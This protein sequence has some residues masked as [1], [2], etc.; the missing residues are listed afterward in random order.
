MYVN[1]A[2]DGRLSLKAN[3]SIDFVAANLRNEAANGQT[4]IISDGRI[5]LGTAK[6]SSHSKQGELSDRNHRHVAQTS[7]AGTVIGAAGDILIS[8]KDDLTIRQGSIASDGGRTTLS[9]RNV[10]I[11]E[12]RQTLDLDDSLYN[13]SRSMVSKT[14]SLDQ[15]RRQHDEAV[16]SSIEGKEVVVRAGQDVN[17]RGSHAVSDGLTV[18]TAGNDVNIT[19]A[20]N[21]YSDHEF[22]ERKRSGLTASLANGVAAVGYSKSRHSLQQDGTSESL[23]LSQI[24][25][26]T[27]TTTLLAGEALNISAGRLNAGGDLNL[28]GRA[29]NLDAAYITDS[30]RSEQQ[31]KQS[32]LSIGVTYN[33]IAAAKTAYDQ[34]TA[35]S[36]NSGSAVGTWFARDLAAFKAGQA[37]ITP[38]VVGGGRSK[39]SA[40]QNNSR[41]QA[42]VSELAAGQHLN[43]IATEGGIRSEGAQISAEG[44]ALLS[45]RDSIRLGFAADDQNQSA[46]SRRSGLSIDNRDHLMPLG[47]FN[48]RGQGEGAL[49]HLTG[50]S[51]SVGGAAALQSGRDIDVIGSTIVAQNNLNLNAAGN[52][53]ILSGQ[54]RQSLSETQV[55]S[56]IG[57][58][59]ISDTEYFSGWMKNRQD[60]HSSQVEQ[61]KSQVGSLGGNVNMQAGAGY[62]QQVADVAAAKDINITANNINILDD[63]NRGSSHQSERDVKIGTFAKVSSPLIELAYAVEDAADSN[64]G[65]RTR[66]LQGMAAAAQGYQ[67][68][69]AVGKVTDAAA[70]NTKVAADA[71]KNGVAVNPDDLQQGAVLAKAEAGVGFKTAN[72]SQN[73]SYADSRR[74]TLSAGGNLTLQS[75]GGDIRLQHTAAT[76]GGTLSLDSAQ[77][78]SLESG[79]SSRHRDGKNSSFGASVGVGVSVG[80]QTG[81]YVYAEAGAT[82]GRQRLD[83]DGHN[84]TELAADK[85]LLAG[86]GDTTL[87]GATVTANRIDADVKGRLNIESVQDT[88]SQ[89]SKQSGAGARIQIALGS[90]WEASGNFNQSKAS[91]SS[92]TVHTQSGLFAGDGGYHI[93]ADS[94]HLKGGAIASTAAKENNGLTANALTFEDI[95]NHSSYNASGV[96]L[97]GGYGGSLSSSEAFQ[98]SPLGQ[99]SAVAGQ[100]ISQGPGYSPTLP[101]YDSGSDSSITR[102]TLSAGRLNIGGQETTT[103]ALGIHSDTETAHQKLAELPDIQ[104]ILRNQQAAASATADITSA[105]RTF[106]GNMAQKAQQKQAELRTQAEQ[107]L[108]TYDSDA[109]VL[110]QAMNEADK[111]AALLLANPEYAQSTQL[112]Q[113]WGNGGSKARA[114]NAVTA[115]LTGVLRGQTEVQATANALAPY[116]AAG[117]GNTFGHGENKNEAAQYAL[118]GILGATLAYLNNANPLSGGS[119]AIASEAAVQSLAAQYN[120]GQTAI[121][122]TTGEFNPNLLSESEKEKLRSLSAAIGSIFGGIAGNSTFNTQLAGVIGQNAVE[123]NGLGFTDIKQMIAELNQAETEQQKQAV[124]N[125]YRQ[126]GERNRQ[127]ELAK[128]NNQGDECHLKTLDGL[129][130]INRSAVA[131]TDNGLFLLF[132]ENG[133]NI[134]A[135]QGLAQ[136]IN[137]R[138]IAAHESQLSGT[139]K[140]AD[141]AV[142]K[143]LPL[144]A[145][146]YGGVKSFSTQIQAHKIANKETKL[147]YIDEPVFNPVGTVSSAQQWTIKSRLKYVSLP[148]EGKIRYI[149]PEGYNPNTPLPRGPNNG[150]IDKFGNEWTKGPSRT[151]NQAFEWDVQLSKTGK[152]KLGWATR[153]GSHLNV[154]LDGKITHK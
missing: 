39:S 109:W 23:T 35:G 118:H 128:C 44:D 48:E 49:N 104:Q 64:A 108:Q 57:S 31:S 135:A 152:S 127:A 25:S 53:N 87:R 36:Q 91:G 17:V 79:H 74:N 142:N 143:G 125:K 38:L 65:D 94:V 56:G 84:P 134:L 19:A 106:S 96:S 78:I 112:A 139:G 90:A 92:N 102:A 60:S 47:S 2:S 45:A 124:L 77:N 71:L 83:A 129:R 50:S 141:F 21:A 95:Q 103:Q 126:K 8:A 58:A 101:Q 32:G 137:N 99:A 100:S 149:P 61:V 70:R 11:S 132:T 86:Q 3:E 151:S 145:A 144:A 119:A 62:T 4:Q 75:T 72:A 51:L 80:A 33:P 82:K 34:S 1:N 5:D 121:D 15:Y 113:D 117:I 9:G 107:E 133:R 10:D 7:E 140:V 131:T 63:Y 52:I 76:A 122:P 18:L 93:N 123:N 16:G 29:V 98:Q 97:S 24:G 148:T 130:D 59:Q 46:Q 66:A 26:S 116:A 40:A 110:Y 115:A 13:E 43:I 54:N 138:D 85:I 73:Q 153:D 42:V 81:V 136:E 88:L 22:H 12:G 30:S 114:L 154:S 67:L 150:Y 41:T 20:E 37:A 105:V 89:T 120:D 6:L 111:Q 68:Y 28:Q 27:G 146:V 55:G 14:T 69:D 147:T